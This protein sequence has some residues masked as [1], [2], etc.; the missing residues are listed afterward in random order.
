MESFPPANH[1]LRGTRGPV[2]AF[3]PYTSGNNTA[4]MSAP[5][6]LLPLSG[7]RSP[8]GPGQQHAALECQAPR[9]SGAP[10]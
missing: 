2:L 7:L 10:L 8:R 6:V 3:E 5:A 9:T 4:A 1:C